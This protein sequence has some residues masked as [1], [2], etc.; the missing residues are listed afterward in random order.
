LTGATG[1]RAFA[2]VDMTKAITQAQADSRFN[3][4]LEYQRSPSHWDGKYHK[5]RLTVDRK[6]VHAQTESGYFAVIGS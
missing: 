2:N 3:Y 5:L 4:T 1:G 6:G